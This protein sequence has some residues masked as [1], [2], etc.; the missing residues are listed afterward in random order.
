MLVVRGRVGCT[1]VG[2]G[3]TAVGC[4]GGRDGTEVGKVAGLHHAGE[5]HNVWR[6]PSG[7]IDLGPNGKGRSEREP[8]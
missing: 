5:V 3:S 8:R 7:S 4:R 6:V 1:A 2:T